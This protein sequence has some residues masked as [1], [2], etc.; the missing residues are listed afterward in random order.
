MASLGVGTVVLLLWLGFDDERFAHAPD[1]ERN[2]PDF[3]PRADGG[4]VDP[5][6][7]RRR[8]RTEL[9]LQRE[10]PLT[11]FRRIASWRSSQ[12]RHAVGRTVCA[13]VSGIDTRK[14]VAT[15]AFYL[16]PLS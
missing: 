5:Q 10:R 7:P 11:Q 3:C 9:S 13:F 4:R 2:G 12:H 16:D 14:D 8:R 15:E 6:Q 1:A